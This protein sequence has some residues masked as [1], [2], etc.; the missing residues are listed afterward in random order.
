MAARLGTRR[1]IRPIGPLGEG[2]AVGVG[3]ATLNALQAVASSGAGGEVAL[4]VGL[5]PWQR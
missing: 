3:E 1:P 5:E 4:S 2:A